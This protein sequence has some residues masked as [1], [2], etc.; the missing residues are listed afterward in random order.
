VDDG[1]PP[2]STTKHGGGKRMVDGRE[3]VN[4]IMEGLSTECQW[5]YEPK[6]LPPKSTLSDYFDLWL[7]GGTLENYPSRA[8]C[9]VP[10]TNRARGQPQRRNHRQPLI[11]LK[12]CRPLY[13]NECRPALMHPN[14]TFSSFSFAALAY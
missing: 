2:I 7:Y 6:D 1:E 5:R 9:E 13:A 12:R 8:L 4:G 11:K 10:Q 14:A 3:I